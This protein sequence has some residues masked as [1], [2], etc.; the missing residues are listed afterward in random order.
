MVV[1]LF[2]F[3]HF[4]HDVFSFGEIRKFCLVPISYFFAYLSVWQHFE[5]MMLIMFVSV[6]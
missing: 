4:T 3:Q 2:F 6:K 5:L 1:P